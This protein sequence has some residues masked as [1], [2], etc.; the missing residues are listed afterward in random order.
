MVC[1]A[2]HLQLNNVPLQAGSEFERIADPWHDEKRTVVPCYR[3]QR[4]CMG[5][6]PSVHCRKQ[7]FGGRF[8]PTPL[9]C[10]FVL[11]A[12]Q[13]REAFDRAFLFRACRRWTAPG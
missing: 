4:S 2:R 1:T 13:K 9:A 6:R 8:R 3:A 11:D 7:R 12:R 10:S 5:R